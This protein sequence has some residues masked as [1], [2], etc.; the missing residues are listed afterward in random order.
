MVVLVDK[1][2]AAGAEIIAGALQGYGRAVVVGGEAT[3][4]NGSI[5]QGLELTQLPRPLQQA[6]VASGAVRL[7]LRNSIVPTG[8]QRN[9][10][11]PNPRSSF[12]R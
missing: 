4:A 1:V 11:A 2:T 5:Q 6:K 3:W 9:W 7:T 12:R 8:V 10:S